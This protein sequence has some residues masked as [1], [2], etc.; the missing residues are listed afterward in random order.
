[1]KRKFI[2]TQVFDRSWAAIGLDDND[3]AII[4]ALPRRKFEI[5]QK[6]GDA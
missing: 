6:K 2:M 5:T 4:F 3:L 1:M